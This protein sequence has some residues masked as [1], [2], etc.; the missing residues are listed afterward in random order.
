MDI[1]DAERIERPNEAVTPKKIE[2]KIH[3]IVLNDRKLREI[4]DLVKI[5]IDRDGTVHHILYHEHLSI[6]NLFSKW[7]PHLLTPDQKQQRIAL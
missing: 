4:A 3:K 5:S 2:K 6:R 7:V 1:N